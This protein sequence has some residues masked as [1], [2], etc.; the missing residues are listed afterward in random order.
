MKVVAQEHTLGCGV[1]CVAAI[2]NTTYQRALSLFSDPSHAWIRG[3]YAV[4]LV[5]ALLKVGVHYQHATFHLATHGEVLQ[6]AGTI[7]YISPSSRYPLGHYLVR[8]VCGWMNPWMNYP[9]I[10]PVR[11]GFEATLPGEPNY[12]LWQVE[13]EAAKSMRS[14]TPSGVLNGRVPS[15]RK[16]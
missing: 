12:I 16:R 14:S 10:H 1:A 7:I 4:E 2:T 6:R 9:R 11:A 13:A 5:N 15:P 3:F 8:G